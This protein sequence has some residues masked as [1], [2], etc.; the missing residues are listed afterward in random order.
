MPHNLMMTLFH[1]QPIHGR[2]PHK[3]VDL[4]I[5]QPAERTRP[6]Q[7]DDI[8][9]WE[10]DGGRIIEVTACLSNKMTFLMDL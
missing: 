10:D 9:R 1:K 3:L 6:E 5:P 4:V 2:S 7:D 8:L